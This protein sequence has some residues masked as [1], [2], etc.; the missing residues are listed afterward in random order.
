[1]V[2]DEASLAL[3]RRIRPANASKRI[4]RQYFPF[5][6]QLPVRVEAQMLVQ[7]L[8]RRRRPSSQRLAGPTNQRE[9]ARLGVD[10]RP[11]RFDRRDVGVFALGSRAR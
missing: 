6:G 1:M 3:I 5:F 11:R 4:N 8:E 7:K 10:G 9:F 2:G